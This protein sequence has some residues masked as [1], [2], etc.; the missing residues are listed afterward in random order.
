MGRL[1]GCDTFQ[2]S[3][4]IMMKMNH[5]MG[6]LKDV[7]V[8]VQSMPFIS[9]HPE[10]YEGV[11]SPLSLKEEFTALRIELQEMKVGFHAKLDSLLLECHQSC[12]KTQ[13]F[14]TPFTPEE[15]S[16]LIPSPDCK[17]SPTAGKNPV[18]I[19]LPAH[20]GTRDM[21]PQGERSVEMEKTA[22]QVSD[23]Q[24]GLSARAPHQ[25]ISNAMA[26]PINCNCE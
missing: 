20:G 12:A 3:C 25:A 16:L 19:P 8:D 9:Q 18:W 10:F 23:T 26:E 13:N 6:L 5:V 21:M 2:Y 22:K 17:T 11:P 7:R 4:M 24:K 1:I 15:S 14:W